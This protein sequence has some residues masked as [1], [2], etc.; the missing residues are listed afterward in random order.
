MN[1]KVL[2]V[3]TGLMVA[4]LAT[5][6]ADVVSGHSVI[7]LGPVEMLIVAQVCMAVSGGM[8]HPDM[9][10]TMTVGQFAYTWLY[11]S[12]NIIFQNL[13]KRYHPAPLPAP[14]TVSA[15]STVTEKTVITGAVDK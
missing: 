12:A 1:R 3:L 11:N 15:T 14:G 2:V 8:P 13:E 6:A 9:L 10:K 7:S 4:K 5:A